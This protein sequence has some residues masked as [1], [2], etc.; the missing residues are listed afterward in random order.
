MS[1]RAA[2][3]QFIPQSVLILGITLTH[4]QD[5]ALGPVECHDVCLG[6]LLKHIKVPLDGIP[7]F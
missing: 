7:S 5:L 3:N 1:S 2:L 4:V 6:L